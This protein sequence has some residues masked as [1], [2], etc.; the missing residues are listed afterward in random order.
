ML[1]PI[2]DERR[3]TLLPYKGAPLTEA[4]GGQT[5]PRAGL[6]DPDG[7]A[8]RSDRRMYLDQGATA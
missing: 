3:G 7:G 8:D 1:G 2:T 5:C 4:E 6:H